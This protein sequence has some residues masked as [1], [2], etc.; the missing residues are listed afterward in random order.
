LANGTLIGLAGWAWGV[1]LATLL[2]PHSVPAAW[3][4]IPYL[5]RSPVGTLVTW[6]MQQLNR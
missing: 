5:L 2:L 4:L 3:L 6:K 1:A